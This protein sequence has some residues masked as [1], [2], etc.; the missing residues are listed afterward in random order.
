MRR[1]PERSA[2]AS[3]DG[4]AVDPSQKAM[5]I[6]AAFTEARDKLQRTRQQGDR[7]TEGVQRKRY[8]PLPEVVQF[9][10]KRHV[11]QQVTKSPQ[12]VR[13]H[14]E[15]KQ[16]PQEFAQGS[17]VGLFCH[18]S[19]RP[20]A[21]NGLR[22]PAPRNQTSIGIDPSVL[23]QFLVSLVVRL[24]IPR[25]SSERVPCHSSR[26]EQSSTDVTI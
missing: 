11:R 17:H 21:A 5:A 18:V 15:C 26:A 14:E 16:E 6:P 13:K 25:N 23:P 19:S 1:D 12:S 24:L 2:P 22:V 4:A 9:S 3:Q 10:R 8:A 20:A 7:A